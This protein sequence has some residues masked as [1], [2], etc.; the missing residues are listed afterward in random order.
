LTARL[1]NILTLATLILDPLLA[2]YALQGAI[3]P[4]Q[5]HSTTL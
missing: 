5:S 4:V 2:K 3:V 1:P